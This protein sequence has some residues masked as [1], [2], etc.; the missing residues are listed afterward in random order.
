MDTLP[1]FF[2]FS[3]AN[4]RYVTLSAMLLTGSTAMVG[5]FTLLKQRPL[6]GDAI[7]H[8]VLPGVY[9]AFFVSGTKNPLY[10]VIGAFIT[11][12]VALLLID[13]IPS[14]SKIKEDTATALILSS[15]FGISIILLTVIQHTGNAQQTGLNNFL[16]GKAASLL[17]EDM[18]IFG[19][20][21]LLVVST[22]M[23]FF[24]EFM[25]IAFDKN[26]AK[27]IH[28]PVKRLELLLTSLTVLAIVMG[29]QAVGVVLMAAILITPPAAARFWTYN[30]KIMLLL[31]ALF[32]L[33]TGL[34]GAFISYTLPNMPTGP[35]IV[36]FVSFI[37]IFS[38]LFAP[39]KG[40]LSKMVQQRQYQRKIL[41]E[42]IL[43]RLYQLGEAD[44]HFFEYKTFDM[45]TEKMKTP[46]Q[47]L[48]KGLTRLVQ[49][50]NLQQQQNTWAFTKTGKN[51]GKRIV[52]K[53]RLWEL[54]LTEYLKI[55]PDHV[56]E[57]AESIEHIITPALEAELITL[58][59]HQRVDPHQSKIT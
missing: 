47:K 52:R 33:I 21:S 58:L 23:L 10:L 51:K 12:W 13:Y 48:K 59:N 41:I 50:G 44:N 54:Y 32:G 11:G 17:K 37:A 39:K 46:I 25:L 36:L 34:G 40:I 18:I 2:S 53:H 14:K 6:I 7:S 57:D 35:W 4:I 1:E 5:A 28:L 45:L 19:T 26:F 24:K 31:S 29:I 49:Q 42:N 43:K 30:L 8:A 55:K 38:F 27:A 9:L 16:F 22:I 56:H 3:S 20:I 15:F